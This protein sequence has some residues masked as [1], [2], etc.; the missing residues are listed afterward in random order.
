MAVSTCLQLITEGCSKVMLSVLFGRR[1]PK[2][3]L[4]WIMGT[5]S[6]DRTRVTLPWTGPGVP[7]ISRQ[8]EGI[9]AQAVRKSPFLFKV[10]IVSDAYKNTNEFN[11]NGVLGREKLHVNQTFPIVLMCDGKCHWNLCDNLLL[12]GKQ[13]GYFWET[14]SDFKTLKFI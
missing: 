3:M 14:K 7:P 11:V 2:A 6:P 12:T 4:R 13:K 10:I 9:P 1:G 8:E 5:P